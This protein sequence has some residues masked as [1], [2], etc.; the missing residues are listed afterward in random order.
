M[1]INKEKNLLFVHIPKTGGSS[2]ERIVK[3]QTKTGWEYWGELANLNTDHAII[4]KYGYI[5]PNLDQTDGSNQRFL[6]HLTLGHFYGIL[7]KE[8]FSNYKKVSIIRNPWDRLVSF[9]EYNLQTFGRMGTKGK[10]FKEWFYSRKISPTLLPYLTVN[11]EIPS[12]L[13]LIH[14]EDY[15]GSVR[16]LFHNLSLDYDDKIFEKKTIRQHY[17]H[18]YTTRMVDELASECAEDISRFNFNF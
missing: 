2:L 14:F 6:Q 4:N 17:R 7:S 9:Y 10:S 18:Y 5:I 11:S 3:E 13:E 12:S 1:P 15:S 8:E 16:E